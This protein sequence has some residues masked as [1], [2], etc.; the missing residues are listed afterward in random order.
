MLD[1]ASSLRRSGAV[2][3][4][5]CSSR[6]MCKLRRNRRYNRLVEWLVLPTG[7][8]LRHRVRFETLPHHHLL[9]TPLRADVSGEIAPRALGE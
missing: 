6:K 5:A 8:E 9:R 1:F 2:N 7:H 4:R 3:V